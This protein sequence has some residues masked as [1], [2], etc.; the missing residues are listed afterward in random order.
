MRRAPAFFELC[1]SLAVV[2]VIFDVDV[3]LVLR[4]FVVRVIWRYSG[5]LGGATFAGA[6]VCV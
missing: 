5:D 2:V 1:E 3:E 6:E 4:R